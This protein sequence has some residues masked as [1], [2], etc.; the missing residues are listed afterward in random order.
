MR[1][2]RPALAAALALATLPAAL[3]AGRPITHEDL[4]TFARLSPPA[5]SH[6]GT[7]AA[8]VVTQPAYDP[9]QQSADLWLLPTDGTGTPRQLTFSKA[10][11]AGPVFSPDGAQ[12]AFT[13]QRE[14]DTAP[15]VYVLDLEQGG[16]DVNAIPQN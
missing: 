11:E 8:V 15:Q 13:V 12:L 9:T 2:F 16:E 1:L 14:G 3:A 5:L 4:W 10:A 6:D 7:R